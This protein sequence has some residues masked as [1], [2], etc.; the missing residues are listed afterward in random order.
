MQMPGRERI[1]RTL[2]FQ[3]PD[4]VPRNLW[5]LPGIEMFRKKDL[6]DVLKHYPE[7]VLLLKDS[8]FFRR[9]KAVSG[10]RYRK[11]KTAIDEW[12]CEWSAAEDGVAGEVKIPPLKSISEV[13]ALHPP[14]E[15]LNTID[16]GEIDTCCS[17]TD[18]FVILWTTIRPFERMQFLLGSEMIFQELFYG[19]KYVFQLK[20]KLHDFYLAELELLCSTEADAI[21]FMDDWGSQHNMLISPDLW[22]KLFKPLY[23]DYCESI[24]ASGKYAFF[25]S[26]G[27]IEP[28]F[29]DLIEIGVD[30]INSQLFCMDIEELGRKH[31]G[32][33][34]FWGEIDRQRIL[35]FGTW[36]QVANAV[37]RVK[38]ALWDVRGGVIAQCEFGI[39]DPVQNIKAV[40]ETWAEVT[41]LDGLA[42]KETHHNGGNN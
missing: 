36:Q 32:K 38:N 4:R 24:H 27:F 22:R 41:R 5:T 1:I 26:D 2:R 10:V 39:L 8:S 31:R 14:Y 35:P 30:A 15:V 34:T 13:D 37:R 23:R 18:L 40:F 16:K 6:I 9:G 33:I 29:P 7:D 17:H 11:N 21:S 28:I 12:G 19:S 3:K 25:H 20:K 42:T